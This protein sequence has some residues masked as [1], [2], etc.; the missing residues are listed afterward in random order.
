MEIFC[1]ALL[2]NR[3]DPE[4]S[5]RKASLWLAKRQVFP[6]QHSDLEIALWHGCISI[7]NQANCRVWNSLEFPVMSVFD[8][9]RIGGTL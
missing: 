9:V 3:S 2:P 1:I 8:P 7:K 4:S 5:Q 6:T